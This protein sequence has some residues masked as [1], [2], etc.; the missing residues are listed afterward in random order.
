MLEYII[1][2]LLLIFSALFS[3]LTL[4]LM[5]LNA[6]ELKRKLSLGDKDAQK[7]Y[8]VRRQGNLLLTT[9][10][11]GNVA[12]NSA[13]AIF[14]G[15]LASGVVAGLVSTALIVIF[16]EIIPQAVFARYALSLGARVAW[17][18]KIFIFILY[19]IAWPISWVLD[20]T[21]GQELATVYSKRE[22]MKIIEEH[23]DHEESDVDEDEERIVLGALT[24]SE[25]RVKNVM[26]PNTVVKMVSSSQKMDRAFFESLSEAGHSRIPVYEDNVDNIVGI[27]FLNDL[28]GVKA[29]G[30]KVVDYMDE[31]VIFVD[32]SQNL[33]DVFN[34]FIKS[35]QHL[36]VVKNQFGTMVGVI[37]LEDVVEEI[38][39]I[40][41]MD[42][43][44]KYKDMRKVARQRINLR[45]D[46]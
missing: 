33:D 4:G 44:D 3:G 15:S 28:I 18:V 10:L 23:E 46:E 11:I 20:K 39:K 19:P 41:I 17:I 43:D 2:F 14:L 5:S 1:V 29:I 37:T 32:E 6:P 45:K 24:Y 42:E 27:L 38:I 13:L 31:R 7:V 22:L 26:T 35:R 25:K 12:V 30:K 8:Q 36:F 9:L 34:L 16:G 21:L 40:E